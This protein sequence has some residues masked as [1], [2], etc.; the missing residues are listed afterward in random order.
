MPEHIYLLEKA[1]HYIEQHLKEAMTLED[2]AFAAN[3]SPWHFHR[4][5]LAF[6]GVT[7][8]EYVRKR[9]LS[10]ASR[11]LAL[12]TKAIRQLAAEYQFESQAA[13]TR[14]FKSFSGCTPREMRRHLSPLLNYQARITLQGK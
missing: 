2:I 7:V 11:E 1:L 8:G 3:Y 4:L 14:S 13:F 5:F 6:T 10:E 9:R 12:G